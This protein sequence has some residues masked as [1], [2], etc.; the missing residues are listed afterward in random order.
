MRAL[1]VDR[2]PLAGLA[3]AA[4]LLAAPAI[5]Q[6][7]EPILDPCAV[8]A[9]ADG[10][11]W[12]QSTWS[13]G[14]QRRDL[15]GG[16]FQAMLAAGRVGVGIRAE[17]IGLPGEFNR[18]RTETFR[19]AQLHLAVHL[20]TLALEGGITCGPAVLAGAAVALELRD[21]KA[22][23]LPKALTVGV[24]GRCSGPGWWSYAAVGQHQALPGVAGMATAH[25]R[26]TD[27]TAWIGDFAVGSQG[28]YVASFGIAI[29]AF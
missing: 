29:K 27:H 25:A 13:P 28:R 21:G 10:W 18:E 2:G 6:E 20:N 22:P 7:P 16:R 24:G 8:T 12:Q 5:A 14:T 26:L 17:A 3:L 15:A 4:A 9:S 23:E 1:V 11:V 19:A